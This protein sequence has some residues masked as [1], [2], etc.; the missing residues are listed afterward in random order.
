MAAYAS[1]TLPLATQ[2]RC[3]AG[4]A[5]GATMAPPVGHSVAFARRAKDEPDE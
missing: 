5:A 1:K 3:A 4:Q 2:T